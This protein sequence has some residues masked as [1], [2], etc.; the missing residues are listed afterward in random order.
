MYIMY[1]RIY[2]Y[3][4][5]YGGYELEGR[6]KSRE[7]AVYVC[8]VAQVVGRRPKGWGKKSA[9]VGVRSACA[10]EPGACPHCPRR[11]RKRRKGGISGATTKSLNRLRATVRDVCVAFVRSLSLFVQDIPHI[12]VSVPKDVQRRTIAK[13][14]IVRAYQPSSSCL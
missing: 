9:G 1:I 11:E 4:E 13:P 7:N 2:M 3:T 6:A 10:Q 12:A 5:H 14:Y 8:E